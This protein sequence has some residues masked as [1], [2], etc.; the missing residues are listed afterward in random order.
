MMIET[1][2]S[3]AHIPLLPA[4]RMRLQETVIAEQ[5]LAPSIQRIRLRKSDTLSL[6]M[7][8]GPRRL[9]T[10]YCI[11]GFAQEMKGGFVLM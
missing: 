3:K 11:Y 8:E 9:F 2:G 6:A 1:E 4:S 5:I 10:S 7:T